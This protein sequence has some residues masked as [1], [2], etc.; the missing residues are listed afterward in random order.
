[1]IPDL[2]AAP[3]T[4]HQPTI[5]VADD[6][7]SI[8]TVLHQALTDAGYRV[9]LAS[10]AAVAAR[11]VE[12]G[13]GD[14]LICDIVMPDHNMLDLLPALRKARPDLPVLVISAQSTFNTAVRAGEL[15]VADYLSKPFDLDRLLKAVAGAFAGHH[16]TPVGGA[17]VPGTSGGHQDGHEP[18]GDVHDGAW[19]LAGRSP[20]MQEIFRTLARAA[21]ARLPVIVTGEKGT[22]K[23]IV[24]R[25]IHDHGPDRD[26][27]FITVDT[28]AQTG[29]DPALTLFGSGAAGG[30]FA[31]ARAGTIFI[32]EIASLS[33]EA[34]NRLLEAMVN[35]EYGAGG[36][37][38]QA[39]NAQSAPGA[40]AHNP[41]QAGT[42][43]GRG[44]RVM[45][46]SEHDPVALI[47]A[48]RLREDLYY[49]LNG[50]L[51]RLPPLRD[52]IG[53]LPELVRQ[54]LKEGQ[55]DGLPAKR[56]DASALAALAAYS[57]PG[58]TRELATFLRRVCVLYPDETITSLIVEMEL[59]A[60]LADVSM[61]NKGGTEGAGASRSAGAGDIHSGNRGDHPS[62]PSG[63]AL[64]HQGS[65]NQGSLAGPHAGAGSPSSGALSG[66]GGLA[67]AVEAHLKRYFDRHGADLPD[68]GLYNRIIQEVE[69]PLIELCLAATKGNQLKASFV[70]G[71]NRNTLRKKIKDLGIAVS[72]GVG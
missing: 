5:L 52:R 27:P 12:G 20:A 18:E 49:R 46:A 45:V 68:P 71:L 70:L 17:G 3:A 38:P 8:R 63:D 41:A 60:S 48:G 7:R 21:P 31:A 23:V 57:W 24:A 26:G 22:G 61:Q 30:R 25:A 50:T 4:P 6:D 28:S 69:R 36:V 2:A 62:G 14:L 42:R 34:Q 55:R 19:V 66:E 47:R 15:G 11:W 53:D 9:K 35:D 43:T 10:T 37:N 64:G 51:V 29:M 1:M 44:T 58:N 40:L 13:E 56:V 67:A 72:K 59:H 39:D 54:V 16:D 32:T 65:G 33:Q